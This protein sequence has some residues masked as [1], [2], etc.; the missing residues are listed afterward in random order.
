M[1]WARRKESY[2]DGYDGSLIE[3]FCGACRRAWKPDV[4]SPQ[5]LDYSVP[6][7]LE[8]QSSHSIKDS[9]HVMQ[10]P[11]VGLRPTATTSTQV[12]CDHLGRLHRPSLSLWKTV[13]NIS[14]RRC[15][16]AIRWEGHQK[17][18]FGSNLPRWSPSKP[19]SSSQIPL[20]R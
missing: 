4:Q 20:R 9:A 19:S 12:T 14:S 3:L 11:T 18:S 1:A 2:N 7:R 13:S 10:S 17:Y 8:P 16:R 5:A 15:R 6:G